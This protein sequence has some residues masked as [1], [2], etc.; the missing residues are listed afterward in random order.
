[1]NATIRSRTGRLHLA[2][3]S[4]TVGAWYASC[5]SVILHTVSVDRA[6]SPSEF[7]GMDDTVCAY[8]RAIGRAVLT[9]ELRMAEAVADAGRVRPALGGS[10]LTV[11][12]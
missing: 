12:H 11:I 8:C 1:M 7:V 9:V 6:V 2:F 5:G 10:S 3:Y 4:S